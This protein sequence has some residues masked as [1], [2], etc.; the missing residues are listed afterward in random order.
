MA[1][2]G[3]PC[4]QPWAACHTRP[5][6]S[7]CG[8]DGWGVPLPVTADETK[9][10]CGYVAFFVKQL[11]RVLLWARWCKQ[12]PP[13]VTAVPLVVVGQASSCSADQALLQIV[14]GALRCGETG[15]DGERWERGE[16]G[17]RHRRR[18]PT[19]CLVPVVPFPIS[20]G[21]LRWAR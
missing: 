15:F 14:P 19:L 1:P 21:A 8:E 11:L 13:N 17:F 4:A 6:P 3:L 12:R 2:S 16:L 7:G 20:R 5:T 10:P 18:G 9:A